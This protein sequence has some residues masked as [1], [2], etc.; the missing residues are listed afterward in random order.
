MKI[1]NAKKIM[2]VAAAALLVGSL[3]SCGQE[4]LT[5]NDYGIDNINGTEKVGKLAT[6]TENG[7]EFAA[8]YTVTEVASGISFASSST[9]KNYPFVEAG[10][11]YTFD[12]KNGN[13]DVATIK[14]LAKG[15]I[16]DL[17]VESKAATGKSSGTTSRS[18]TV[19]YKAGQYS[20]AFTQPTF[21][22]AAASKVVGWRTKYSYAREDGLNVVDAINKSKTRTTSTSSTTATYWTEED[23]G[24]NSFE[25]GIAS[26]LNWSTIGTGVGTLSDAQVAYYML[27][28]YSWTV[29]TQTEVRVGS[30]QNYYV[31]NDKKVSDAVKAQGN[32]TDVYVAYNVTD[33]T[34]YA[35]QA[36]NW[37]APA[38][39]TVRPNA[40]SDIGEYDSAKNT[41]TWKKDVYK[42]AKVSVARSGI[43]EPKVV[44]TI[45]GVPGQQQITAYATGVVTTANNQ[46]NFQAKEA[47]KAGTAWTMPDNTAIKAKEYFYKDYVDEWYKSKRAVKSGDTL[48]FVGQTTIYNYLTADGVDV[49]EHAWISNVNP[50]TTWKETRCE[51]TVVIP[52]K[53]LVKYADAYNNAPVAFRDDT[54]TI[55]LKG[56]QSYNVNLDASII[57]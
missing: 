40:Y 33:G 32:K 1:V 27:Q 39:A 52:A 17:T 36:N 47:V 8:G 34:A 48:E 57:R 14:I 5:Q 42:R 25:K 15:G 3:V 19:A 9:F 12:L 56:T 54:V 55:T 28:G 30:E 16:G 24:N 7:I 13:N 38:G 22:G 31:M 11:V 37:A 41:Y 4:N 44:A 2:G 10:K 20:I 18:A 43:A 21:G 46:I 23:N 6:A 51:K 26:D 50:T 45:E 53:V 35:Q 49:Y 29:T